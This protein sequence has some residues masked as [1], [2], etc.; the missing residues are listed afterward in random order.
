MPRIRASLSPALPRRFSTWTLDVQVFLLSWPRRRPR[1]LGLHQR[2]MYPK[3]GY[4]GQ[5]GP[6]AY[7]ARFDRPPAFYKEVI[8]DTLSNQSVAAERWRVTAFHLGYS[9]MGAK[10]CEHWIGRVV[11]L[12]AC[13]MSQSIDIRFIE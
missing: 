13:I 2:K 6:A 12:N 1:Q 3:I 10:F 11:Y 7:L 5:A 8:L 4:F 9:R